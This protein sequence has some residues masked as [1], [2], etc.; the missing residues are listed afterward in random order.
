M[1]LPENSIVILKGN[2]QGRVFS[3]SVAGAKDQKFISFNSKNPPMPGEFISFGDL[4]YYQ[5]DMLT[6]KSGIEVGN[7]SVKLGKPLKKDLQNSK[8]Y[9]FEPDMNL[10]KR[11][12]A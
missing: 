3:D 4:D 1:E 5:V 8:G 9:I 11:E 10:G 2:G 7:F 6:E 12:W